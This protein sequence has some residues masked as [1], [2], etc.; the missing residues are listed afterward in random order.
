MLTQA[1]GED[2]HGALPDNSNIINGRLTLLSKN[3]LKLDECRCFL[4]F[5][6]VEFNAII[7]P[8]SFFN[9]SH[10]EGGLRNSTQN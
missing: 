2:E 6:S 1:L 10:Y 7:N 3:W 5:L 8:C 9:G 4:G